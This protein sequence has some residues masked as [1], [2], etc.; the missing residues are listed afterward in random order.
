MKQIDLK[1]GLSKVG[2]PLIVTSNTPNLCFLLDTGATHNVIFSF[3]AKALNLTS[4]SLVEVINMSGIDGQEQETQG[5]SF[6]L[7]LEEKEIISEFYILDATE[8]IRKIQEETRIQIHGI[9]GVPFLDKYN[10]IVD[11]NEQILIL[12]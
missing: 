4:N 7:Q 5:L 3:V 12:N 2:L 9:L 1:Y 6:T 10:C 8:A 11:F